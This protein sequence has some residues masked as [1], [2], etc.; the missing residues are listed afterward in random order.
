MLENLAL[1]ARGQH[2]IQRRSRLR[3]PTFSEAAR[4]VH[5]LRSPHWSGPHTASE[6]IR[7]LERHVFSE[8]GS[9]P[10]SDITPA[11]LLD[12]LNPMWNV[13]HVTASAVRTRIGV[14]MKWAIAQGY[15]QD[16]PADAVLNVLPRAR[17]VAVH[18]R[19]LP[20]R[21]VPA[22]IAAVYSSAASQ[23]TKLAFHFLALTAVRS[24]EVRGARWE[25]I[26]LDAA[27]WVIP[28]RRM[29][30]R[31]EHRVPLSGRAVAVLRQARALFPGADLVFPSKHGAPIGRR[32]F[33]KL[34]GELGVG[35]VP[36]GFRSSFRDWC[37]ETGVPREVAERCLAHVVGNDVELAY[38]RSDLYDRR[39][40]VME[41]WA[42]YLDSDVSGQDDFDDS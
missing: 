9:L 29:K 24:G 23:S 39:V 35:A 20:H 3:A 8:L 28:A 27:M 19:A 31:V 10:I 14:V 2:P 13:K 5:Q 18:H 33:A 36:H 40:E 26:D 41:D 38:A 32:T 11:Q 21:E 17:H 25:E 22:V 30:A 4:R 42:R 15:R 12:V 37:G 6:W 7:S 34:L 16:N 1:F